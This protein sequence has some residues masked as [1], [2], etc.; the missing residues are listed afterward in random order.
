MDLLTVIHQKIFNTAFILIGNQFRG[1][2]EK[3]EF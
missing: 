3:E 1:R 2:K